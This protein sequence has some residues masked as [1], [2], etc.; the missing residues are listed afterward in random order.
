MAIFAASRTIRPAFS[1]SPF[2][3][4]SM[5]SASRSSLTMKLAR[6]PPFPSAIELFPPFPC[7]FDGISVSLMSER[8]EVTAPP[9]MS[10]S[11]GGYSHRPPT[12]LVCSFRSASITRI[13][14]PASRTIL[15][16]WRSETM[17]SP[18]L[19]A[20]LPLLMGWNPRPSIYSLRSDSERGSDL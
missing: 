16:F 6:P 13:L 11:T 20:V 17:M 10:L 14:P 12:S 8:L 2:S 19:K 18:L 15:F 5:Y 1:E 4:A 9:S 7:P 3:T